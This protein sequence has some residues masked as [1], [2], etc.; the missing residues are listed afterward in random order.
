[1]SNRQ[2]ADEIEKGAKACYGRAR[3]AYDRT[4]KALEER[5]R[6]RERLHGGRV[7]P[8]LE[9]LQAEFV[10]FT[11]I[12][13]AD[14]EGTARRVAISAEDPQVVDGDGRVKSVAKASAVGVGGGGTVGGVAAG[15]VYS[16][17]ATWGTASTGT[18]IGTLS[19]AAA[20]NATL[21]AL[22]GGSLA[23]GGG[24]VV[25]GTAVLG[26]VVAV[27]VI[28]AGVGVWWHLGKKRLAEAEANASELNAAA[29]DLEARHARLD[30]SR[31]LQDRLIVATEQLVD[32]LSARLD[33]VS[34][35]SA[36]CRLNT[37]SERRQ[38]F[39]ARTVAVADALA[40]VAQVH[41]CGPKGE[42]SRHGAQAA[43]DAED[44]LADA[45]S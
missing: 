29:K 3:R 30:R 16:G 44:F 11:A 2:R 17:V 41:V 21:A 6:E 15:L 37:L 27:P 34:T 14:G 32:D 7:A 19:G 1:M 25:A 22:G 45:L 24:G 35:W 31:A 42:P 40:A 12:E 5:G 9:R 39:L 4:V 18:A 23:T 8:V 20:S 13:F 26:G 43:Q 10:R 38:A 28:L 36:R 33:E